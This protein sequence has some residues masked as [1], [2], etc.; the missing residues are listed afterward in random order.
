MILFLTHSWNFKTSHF[1]SP[2]YDRIRIQKKLLCAFAH[3]RLLETLGPV[4]IDGDNIVFRLAQPSEMSALRYLKRN[5]YA[6]YWPPNPSSMVKSASVYIWK[7]VIWEYY[8]VCVKNIPD[9]F[10]CIVF[11]CDIWYLFVR[12]F[13]LV[14]RKSLLISPNTGGLIWIRAPAAWSLISYAFQANENSRCIKWCLD[15]FKDSRPLGR[16]KDR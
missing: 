3:F 1:R 16:L 8:G 14:G 9:T 5:E 13:S 11:I 6:E 10:F 2:T 7:S 4:G 12:V 15:P